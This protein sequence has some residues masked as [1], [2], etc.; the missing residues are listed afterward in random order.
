MGK[1][2]VAGL[3][4]VFLIVFFTMVPIGLWVTAKFSGVNISMASLVA[5]RFRRLSP[6]KIVNAMIKSHQAGLDIS[7][8][9]L[10][11]H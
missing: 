6:S 2:F 5:M 7:N 3:V 9:N 1:Y 4:V 10:E 8:N 11:S